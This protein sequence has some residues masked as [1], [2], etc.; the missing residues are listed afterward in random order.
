VDPDPNRLPLR[1]GSERDVGDE[2]S[3]QAFAI[4]GSGGRRR[5]QP[6]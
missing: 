2:R 3:E 1:L 6:G 5:P 4:P